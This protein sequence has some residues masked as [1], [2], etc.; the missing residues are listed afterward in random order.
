MEKGVEDEMRTK[1]SFY[2]LIINVVS[3]IIVLL[4]GFL[5]VRF[6]INLYGSEVN[7]MQLTL[8]QFITY[9]NVF[10]LAYSL[11]FRQLLY[12]PLAEN[13]KQR[14]LAIYHGSRTIF[15]FTGIVLLISGTVFSFIIPYLTNSSIVTNAEITT[16][17]IILFTPFALSYFLMG[18]SFVIAADQ[19]EYK[20]NIWIQGIATL[21]M[22]LMIVFILLKLPY[23][24]IFIIEGL[25]V[26]IANIIAYIISIKHYPWLKEKPIDTNNKEFMRNIKYTITYRLSIIANNNTDNI[27]ISSF[28]GYGLVSIYGAYSYFIEAINR[29]ISSII[30]APINSFGHLFNDD[31][32]DP[33][34]VFMEL[35]SFSTYL[36]TIIGVCIFVTMNQLIYFWIGDTSYV[37]TP[38]ASFLFAINIFYITQREPILIC[39]D[40]NGLFKNAVKNSCVI[41]MV[42]IIFSVMLVQKFEIVGILLATFIS[43]WTVD[44]TYTPVLVYREVFNFKASRYYKL[45]FTRLVVF[46]SLCLLSAWCWTYFSVFTNERMLN[47]LFAAGVLGMIV[48]VITT[49]I[50]FIAYRAFRDLITRIILLMKGEK[51]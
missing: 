8:M 12:K 24:T 21:R 30:T 9:F 2:N 51:E 15:K 5:K 40:T 1:H 23:I 26:L 47:F 43:W 44:F 29:I 16:S 11:A 13:N 36:G 50:Y 45:I 31:E 39:R 7:G 18:P 28:F 17:F 49:V 14:I 34:K 19:K 35:Y 22:L 37:L 38:F 32:K 6:F 46:I 27:I 10:E 42:K 3:S 25:Q 4:L 41:I 20:I 48:F 33:Y